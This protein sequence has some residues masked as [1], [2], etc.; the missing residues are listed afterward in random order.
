MIG[1]NYKVSR[2]ANHYINNYFEL[3]YYK[4]SGFIESGRQ[5]DL[6]V[7]TRTFLYDYLCNLKS[8]QKHQRI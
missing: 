8:K 7:F 5:M 3:Y 2:K 4:V 1:I 6:Y